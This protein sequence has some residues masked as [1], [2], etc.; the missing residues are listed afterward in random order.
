MRSVE[1]RPQLVQERSLGGMRGYTRINILN[2]ITKTALA[3]LNKK[4]PIRCHHHREQ[5]TR[6]AYPK[7]GRTTGDGR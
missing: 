4:P 1:P 7:H 6:L 2:F 3:K 5:L